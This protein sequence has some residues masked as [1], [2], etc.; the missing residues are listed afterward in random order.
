MISSFFEHILGFLLLLSL[1]FVVLF[2]PMMYPRWQSEY[3]VFCIP[4]A[5]GVDY[6]YGYGVDKQIGDTT[7]DIAIRPHREQ[8]K[9]GYKSF[10]RVSAPY[11]LE[12]LATSKTLPETELQISEVTLKV[13]GQESIEIVSQPIT[14]PVH[15]D[16]NWQN[17]RKIPISDLVFQDGLKV[18]LIVEAVDRIDNSTHNFETDYVGKYKRTSASM[19]S[20]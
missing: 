16:F 5:T 4:D 18:K 14:I 9:S 2:L 20:Q 3:Q 1:L 15:Q 6:C 19:L 11:T 17:S 12:L 8:S 10:T 7:V 13:E